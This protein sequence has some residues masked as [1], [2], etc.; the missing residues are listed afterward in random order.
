MYS[1]AKMRLAGDEAFAIACRPAGAGLS[2]VTVGLACCALSALSALSVT[3]RL[4][5]PTDVVC[6]AVE[7]GAG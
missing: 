7:V 2:V 3:W 4:E 1:A 5:D 6:D